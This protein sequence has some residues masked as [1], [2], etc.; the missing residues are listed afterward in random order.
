MRT[1]KAAVV[2]M[3]VLSTLATLHAR[4]TASSPA[5]LTAEDRAQIQEL[6]ARYATA[7]ASCASDEYASLFTADGKFISDDFRGPKH[8]SLYGPNGGTL[9][10]HAKLKELVET[11]E[12]CMP[13][14][15]KRAARAPRTAPNVV[16]VPAPEGARGTISLANNG[17]YED[18]YV[19]TDQGWRFKVRQVVM[20]PRAAERPTSSAPAR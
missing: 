17:R 2:C 19:R 10:G 9:V 13:P 1:W 8:R 4:Q 16:I 14:D 15:P 7:L 12:F 6:T 5:S 3:G 18:L 11:E 20:P